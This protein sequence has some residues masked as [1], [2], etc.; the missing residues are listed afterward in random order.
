MASG[1]PGNFDLGG[2]DRLFVAF[3][4]AAE[5]KGSNATNFCYNR[6]DEA[7]TLEL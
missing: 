4:P 6:C 2:V 3:F 5:E 7:T 1:T